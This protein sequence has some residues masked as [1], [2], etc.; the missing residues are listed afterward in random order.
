MVR[1][2]RIGFVRDGARGGRSARRDPLVGR[3]GRG[4][5]LFLALAVWLVYTIGC[6]YGGITLLCYTLC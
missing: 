3:A 4:F 2:N 6:P 5:R 1:S